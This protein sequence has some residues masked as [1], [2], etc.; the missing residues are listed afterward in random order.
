VRHSKVRSSKPRSPGEIRANPILCLQVRHIGRST[1]DDIRIRPPPRSNH[2]RFSRLRSVRFPTLGQILAQALTSSGTGSEFDLG[3][4]PWEEPACGLGPESPIPSGRGRASD[5]EHGAAHL[6]A[7]GVLRVTTGTI[8]IR[9]PGSSRF[10]SPQVIQSALL[11]RCGNVFPAR[12]VV[13]QVDNDV[14]HDRTPLFDPW[15]LIPAVRFQAPSR[16]HENGFVIPREW[17]RGPLDDE[18]ASR[19]RDPCNSVVVAM[20]QSTTRPNGI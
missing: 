1:M 7:A 6:G 5:G 14:P 17:F 4:R 9:V 19:A 15:L 10:S 3:Y 20:V 13:N 16:D 11:P 2:M 12:L 18:T 8:R